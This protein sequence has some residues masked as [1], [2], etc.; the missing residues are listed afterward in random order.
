MQ[1][2]ALLD[3]KQIFTNVGCMA[4]FPYPHENNALL[5]NF[6]VAWVSAVSNMG[7]MR[8][9]LFPGIFIRLVSCLL[10]SAGASS[11]RALTS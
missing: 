10:I 3:A 6:I 4:V 5:I 8:C 11:W 1:L 2:L 9:C 7:T